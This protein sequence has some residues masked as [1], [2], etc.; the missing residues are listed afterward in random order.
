LKLHHE[1]SDEIYLYI[2]SFNE[3]YNPICEFAIS[4]KNV[5]KLISSLYKEDDVASADVP[6]TEQ[7]VSMKTIWISLGLLL[8]SCGVILV[9]IGLA[10][11]YRKKLKLFFFK[12]CNRDRGLE[13]EKFIA[14][15]DPNLYNAEQ[16]RALLN[17]NHEGDTSEVVDEQSKKKNKTTLN[18]ST[19]PVVINCKNNADE[20]KT[21]N[22]PD[23]EGKQEILMPPT[24]EVGGEDSKFFAQHDPSTYEESWV[25]F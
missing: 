25:G 10:I 8:L 18:P 3:D 15:N 24:Q 22:D 19:P 21:L 11:C 13:G 20:L 14:P 2:Y 6:I 7:S 17:N 23:S 16:R 5:T 4:G 9:L 12:S 1:I